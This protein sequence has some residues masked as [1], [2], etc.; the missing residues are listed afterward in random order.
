MGLTEVLPWLPQGGAIGLLAAVA[1]MVFT[2]RLVPRRQHEEALCIERTRGDDWRDAYRA[3]D[4]RAEV[5]DRQM[6]EVLTFV[7]GRR[8]AA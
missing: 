8:E 2:G 6:S 5:L 7:R 3:T 4:A 1:W